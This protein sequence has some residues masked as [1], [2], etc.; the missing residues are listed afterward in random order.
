MCLKSEKISNQNIIKIYS[1]TWLAYHAALNYFLC[2]LYTFLNCCKSKLFCHLI[3]CGLLFGGIVFSQLC[4]RQVVGGSKGQKLTGWTDKNNRYLLLFVMLNTANSSEKTNYVKKIVGLLPACSG[5]Q[6]GS[7][8][9]LHGNPCCCLPNPVPAIQ[10][11]N[12]TQQLISTPR[13]TSSL[14][15][16]NTQPSAIVT[17]YY[18]YILCN[19]I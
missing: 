17:N 11:Q 19:Y 15:S 1:W 12:S 13:H 5:R 8:T 6:R 14:P 2:I 4:W 10:F 18:Q 16:Q 7:G 9:G 3:M